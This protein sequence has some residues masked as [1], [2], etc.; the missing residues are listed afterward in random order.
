MLL[1]TPADS[2]SHEIPLPVLH[3]PEFDI[4]YHNSN[5]ILVN[6]TSQNDLNDPTLAY[7][8]STL[9]SLPPSCLNLFRLLD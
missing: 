8:V 6:L 4:S 2:L 1:F 5:S 7:E 3:P 9:F